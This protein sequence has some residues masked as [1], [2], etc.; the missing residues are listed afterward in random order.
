MQKITQ[1][2]FLLREK[3]NLLALM[4]VL[5]FGFFQVISVPTA[6]ARAVNTV[7]D[8]SVIIVVDDTA[9]S[10]CTKRIE[11]GIGTVH[12]SVKTQ[13]CSPGTILDTRI[14]K[15]SKAISQNEIYVLLPGKNASNA[16]IKQTFADMQ[17]LRKSKKASLQSGM[18]PSLCVTGQVTLI[19]TGYPGGGNRIR[20]LVD[21]TY[22]N[23]CS[24]IFI[25]NVQEQGVNVP[26]D[27]YYAN[28]DFYANDWFGWWGPFGCPQVNN[29]YTITLNINKAEPYGDYYVAGWL[30][31]AVV[32]DWCSSWAGGHW[33]ESQSS[34][35]LD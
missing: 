34:F 26:N 30:N 21:I 17:K 33:Y 20:T 29:A 22:Y 4:C 13:V 25:D 31:A 9:N 2:F 32:S 28:Q 27:S 3:V 6:S 7:S 24:G 1:R 12:E 11:Q 15:K 23:S 8:P 35:L 14:V 16:T 5:G 10:G 19:A 18:T